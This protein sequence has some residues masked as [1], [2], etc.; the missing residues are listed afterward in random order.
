MFGI[1]IALFY[2]LV[3]VGAI[4]LLIYTIISRIKE[5]KDEETNHKDYKNY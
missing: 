1:I 5:K 4:V 3:F 2:A